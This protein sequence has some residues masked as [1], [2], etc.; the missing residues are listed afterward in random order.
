MLAPTMHTGYRLDCMLRSLW[1]IVQFH[2][3]LC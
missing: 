3:L 1:F 2:C